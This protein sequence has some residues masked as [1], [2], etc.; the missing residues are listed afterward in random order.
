MPAS[1]IRGRRQSY[2]RRRGGRA[3]GSVVK[4]LVENALDAR[5]RGVSTF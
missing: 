5:V 3:A 1:V 4:E 2:R